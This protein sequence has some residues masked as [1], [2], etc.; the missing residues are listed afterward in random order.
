MK[1][2]RESIK[3]KILVVFIVMLLISI[4]G[5]NMRTLINSENLIG[6]A[7]K[8]SA[9]DAATGD[10]LE[11]YTFTS[12]SAGIGV[13]GSITDYSQTLKQ[14]KL[15]AS[16]ANQTV[17]IDLG[18]DAGYYT[19]INIDTTDVYD[20]GFNYGA[21]LNA[22]RIYAFSTVTRD[23]SK[24]V[25]GSM[26]PIG[27]NEGPI[28]I[29]DPNTSTYQY[30]T[31]EISFRKA[32]YAYITGFCDGMN[33]TSRSGC[34]YVLYNGNIVLCGNKTTGVIIDGPVTTSDKIVYYATPSST[35][36]AMTTVRSGR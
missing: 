24:A 18:D 6:T 22:S 31:R 29:Y 15:S 14:I 35:S 23:G 7:R 8:A 16:S 36:G 26:I 27:D 28:K 32:G 1:E 13:A 19:Q 17:A 21:Y 4:A 3:A 33:D 30:S 2:F 5:M 10:V 25:S 20:A 34:G 9:N 12:D 11:N